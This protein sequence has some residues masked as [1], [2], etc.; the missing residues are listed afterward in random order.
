MLVSNFSISNIFKPAL[1]CSDY[2]SINIKAKKK[3]KIFSSKSC[4]AILRSFSVILL[5]IYFEVNKIQSN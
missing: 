1:D 3:S 2:V 5:V 4:S